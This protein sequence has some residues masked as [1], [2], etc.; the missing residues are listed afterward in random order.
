MKFFYWNKNFE[1]GIANLDAQHRRL[2]DLINGLAEL[3]TDGGKLPQVQT[4]IGQLMDYAANHFSDEEELL[5]LSSLPQENKDQHKAAHKAFVD[6]TQTLFKRKDLLQAEVAEQVLEFLTTWLISHILGTDMKLAQSIKSEQPEQQK[7]ETL[8]DISPA[9]RLLIG[10]LTETERRFRLISDQAP[11]MIWVSD[12]SGNRGFINRAWTAFVGIDETT[13]LN[14]PY[15]EHIHPEDQTNYKALI[16]ELLAN[17]RTADAEYRLHKYNNSYAWILEKIL[18]RIDTN[19]AF[20]GLIASATDITAIKQAE[21][22][23]DQSNK[24]LEAEVARR[25]EQLEQLMLT[26]PL[27]GI[28]N[29]RMLTLRLEEETQRAHRTQRPLTAVFFDLDHFKRINDTYGHAAGDAV[30]IK[31]AEALKSCNRDYDLLGRFGGEEFVMVLLETNMDNAMKLAERARA[32]IS[33]LQIQDLPEQI[34]ISAGM[35]ELR[36]N[37]TWELL[38]QR[39][40]AA[41]YRAKKAGRNCVQAD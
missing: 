28:G 3:I 14:T 19:G 13:A 31:V 10:A 41:L 4:L 1:I 30:L 27:T 17:P 16:E 8:I 40:D 26:D 24:E 39:S 18:P 23:L 20:M 36:P 35:A 11:A 21:A 9:E 29:R 22:L 38:L 33:K 15:W 34:T 25:T 12:A 7:T 2:V 5:I 32:A 6:K 37:E